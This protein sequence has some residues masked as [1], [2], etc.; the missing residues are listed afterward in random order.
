MALFLSSRLRGGEAAVLMARLNRI[1]GHD[2]C[3]QPFASLART[4]QQCDALIGEVQ[5]RIG[6]NYGVRSP[7]AAMAER[8]GLPERPLDRR[9]RKHT[10]LT[11][12]EYV[13]KL[14]LAA[15]KQAR[16]APRLANAGVA[17]PT[18]AT[19]RRSERGRAV[20]EV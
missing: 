15:A 12:K 6:E 18:G 5:A 3:Q 17:A 4:R 1:D 19:G 7:V 16:G 14:Q 20:P 11:P 13:P 9:M 8:S 10:V 2:V